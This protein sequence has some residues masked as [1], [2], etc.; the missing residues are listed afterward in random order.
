[1]VLPSGEKDAKMSMPGELVACR[2]K[3]P[4]IRVETARLGRIT[5]ITAAAAAMTTKA[6]RANRARC[7][8]EPPLEDSVATFAAAG[9][10]ASLAVGCTASTTFTLAMKR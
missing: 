1:M 3:G 6:G 5:Q 9:R 8:A 7:H 2:R 10:T 4:E